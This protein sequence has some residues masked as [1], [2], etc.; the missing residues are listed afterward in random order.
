MPQ[1]TNV[2]INVPPDQVAGAYAN[3]VGVWHSPHEFAI[4]FCVNQP[5]SSGPQTLAAQVV[6]R[7]RIPTT[8]VFDLLRALSENLGEYESEYGPIR[9]PGEDQEG[10]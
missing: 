2:T 6:S 8:I 9:Q 5:Y 10:E 4:D 3:V 7:V 1:S